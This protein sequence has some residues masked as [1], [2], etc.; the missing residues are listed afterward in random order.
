MANNVRNLLKFE[1]KN[2][3]ETFKKCY[4][5]KNENGEYVFDFNKIVLMPPELDIISTS[6]LDNLIPFFDNNFKW[7]ENNKD[8]LKKAFDIIGLYNICDDEIVNSINSNIDELSVN[9]FL[10][11]KLAKTYHENLK[12][13]KYKDW[14]EWRLEYWGT[15]LNADALVQYDDELMLCFNTPNTP[16]I[17]VFEEIVLKYPDM[18]LELAFVDEASNFARIIKYNSLECD[19]K[20]INIQDDFC[21]M[22][23]NEPKLS[24]ELYF[25]ICDYMYQDN[26]PTN[27]LIEKILKKTDF[28]LFV[29]NL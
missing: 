26:F 2:D 1:S 15:K 10:D 20:Y 27:D 5:E 4:I 11:F 22:Y 18:N 29:K 16:P 8:I 21:N 24:N 3:Y 19:Y 6:D 14:Y 12:K 28:M 13:Y 9:T 23:L 7:I 25:N 17:K